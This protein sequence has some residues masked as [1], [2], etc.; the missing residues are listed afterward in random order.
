MP[1]EPFRQVPFGN[2]P[3]LPTVP[4]PWGRTT[5]ADVTIHTTDLGPTKIAVRAYGPEAA[6]PRPGHSAP[7]DTYLAR[8]AA[9]PLSHLA[10]RRALH[11]HLHDAL[12]V[13]QMTKFVA[14]LKATEFPIRLLLV[15]AKRDPMV[16]PNVGEKLHAL[17]PGAQITWLDRG[18][19][20]RPRR[21]GS[22]VRGCRRAVSRGWR[23]VDRVLV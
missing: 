10:G 5:P 15:Y 11:R 9:A 20:L 22:S 14:M 23:R 13:R 4:H 1:T 18:L 19:A 17:V 8:R 12:D 21:R 6:P 3:D 2:V 7:P 16:P